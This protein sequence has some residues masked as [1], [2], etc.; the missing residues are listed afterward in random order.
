MGACECDKVLRVRQGVHMARW[1][2]VGFGVPGELITARETTSATP[3]RRH[4][5]PS[6]EQSVLPVIR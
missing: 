1:R 3:M 4:N 2:Q 6:V 5:E